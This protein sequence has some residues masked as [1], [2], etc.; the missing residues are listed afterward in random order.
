[1]KKPRLAAVTRF[2][3]M[4]SLSSVTL[5]VPDIS[6]A[7]K[8][9]LEA[10][11]SNVPVKFSKS[12]SASSGFRGYTISL[13][14]A[15]PGDAGLLF[16]AAVTAGATVLKPIAKSLWGVGGVIQAPDGAI[17]KLATSAKKDTTD[18]SKHL[19]SVVILIAASD[20]SATKKFYEDK[21]FTV[22]KSF[23]KYVEFD[24][25]PSPIGFGLYSIK[26]LAKDA[27]VAPE[28]GHSH[29]IVLNGD[30]GSFTDPDG[31][32]WAS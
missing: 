31:F 8:F 9:Y 20:V 17:I 4:T 1:M 23:G 24:L 18:I 14:V 32:V 12:D 26:A 28:H 30:A 13:L 7:E 5:E 6:A 19:E 11:G 21:G 16:D 29:H 3:V 27:G 15:Q 10:F 22:G 25:K 2:A